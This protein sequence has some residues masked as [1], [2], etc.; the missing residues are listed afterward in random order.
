MKETTTQ[1]SKILYILIVITTICLVYFLFF[2]YSAKN[3]LVNADIECVST[4]SSKEYINLSESG[5]YHDANKDVVIIDYINDYEV[6]VNWDV[7]KNDDNAGLFTIT[8]FDETTEMIKIPADARNMKV[9]F[10]ALGQHKIDVDVIVSQYKK[11]EIIDTQLY[12]IRI[13][14]SITNLYGENYLKEY[15]Y[16]F[17]IS[18]NAEYANIDYYI[19]DDKTYMKLWLGYI[20]ISFN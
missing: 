17:Y 10:L 2:S 6:M 19:Y 4:L 18:P 8:V 3:A 1:N 9:D 7:R 11:N 13:P 12:N 5:I 16:T 20:D 15:S 14:A